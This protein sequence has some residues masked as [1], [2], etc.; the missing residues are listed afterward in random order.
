VLVAEASVVAC[1][2]DEGSMGG[3]GGRALGREPSEPE[4]RP[5]RTGRGEW[6]ASSRR[7]SSRRGGSRR[8]GSRCGVA[9]GSRGGGT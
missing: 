3:Q 5:A 4:N 9:N 8:D 7:D 2:E 1:G 6:R